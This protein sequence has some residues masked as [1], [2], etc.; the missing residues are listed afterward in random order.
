MLPLKDALKEE[1][2]TFPCVSQSFLTSLFP[3]Y[4]PFLQEWHGILFILLQLSLL[5]YK[6]QGFGAPGL[7][8]WLSV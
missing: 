2:I 5:T 4:L 7:V 6:T 8:S 3:R 1:Q